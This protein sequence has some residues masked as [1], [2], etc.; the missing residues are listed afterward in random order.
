MDCK[1]KWHRKLS[2]FTQ[3]IE[4]RYFEKNMTKIEKVQIRAWK[5][6]EGFCNISYEERL[7]RFNI[8]SLKAGSV[9]GDL[10]EI[11]KEIHALNEKD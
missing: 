9:R 6:L 5:I 4:G 10:I 7:K 1:N 2:F 8:I 11:Y 3:K